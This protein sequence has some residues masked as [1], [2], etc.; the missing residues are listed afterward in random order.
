MDA[1][2]GADNVQHR[3]MRRFWR[4]HGAA[5]DLYLG[6]ILASDLLFTG[7]VQ[8]C[9]DGYQAD[10]RPVQWLTGHVAE[11][12]SDRLRSTRSNLAGSTERVVGM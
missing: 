11:T 1:P 3:H 6:L 10:L 7:F 9:V 8:E 2:T 12:R 4:A 5:F